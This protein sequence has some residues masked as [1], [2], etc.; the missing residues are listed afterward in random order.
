MRIQITVPK[1]GLKSLARPAA[2]ASSSS[3]DLVLNAGHFLNLSEAE[4][5]EI[6]TRG[7]LEGRRVAVTGLDAQRLAD[8]ILQERSRCVTRGR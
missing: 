8:V 6:L 3:G 5:R 4:L 2:R 7:T 1:T